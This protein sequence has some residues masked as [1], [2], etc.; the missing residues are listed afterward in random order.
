M[1]QLQRARIAVDQGMAEDPGRV[2][3]RHCP[4]G[5]A[6]YWSSTSM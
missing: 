1:I 3:F 5:V 4:L 6:F 2:A